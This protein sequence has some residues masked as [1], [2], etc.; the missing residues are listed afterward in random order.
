MNTPG[1]QDPSRAL[2]DYQVDTAQ[3]YGGQPLQPRATN[4]PCSLISSFF[5]QH[6]STSIAVLPGIGNGESRIEVLPRF[7]APQCPHPIPASRS[8]APSEDGLPPSA[9]APHPF[10]YRTR[11]LSP[12]APMVLR[13]RD[14]G[15]V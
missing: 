13:L 14:R 10:P 8:T 9:R 4:R 7:P 11:S 12:A 1:S 6:R 3:V 5:L 15:R 2:G